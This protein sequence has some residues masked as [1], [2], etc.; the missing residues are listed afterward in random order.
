MTKIVCAAMGIAATLIWSPPA[1]ADPTDGHFKNL[2]T[3]SPPMLCQVSDDADPEARQSVTCQTGT[4]TG[5]PV[6]PTATD[7]ATQHYQVSVT[8]T[9][10]LTY[11]DANLPTVGEEYVP[12]DLVDG[13]VYHL[14]GW[15]VT[16]TGAGVTFTYDDTGHGMIIDRNM[17]A[18]A[19]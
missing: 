4:M 2:K 8:A 13:T 18:S 15:T 9:G 1:G 16:P 12:L 14:Q 5:F 6:T 11:R 10:R 7:F 17:T 19:V 3:Q